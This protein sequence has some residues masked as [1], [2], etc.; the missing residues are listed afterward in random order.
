M[1]EAWIQM[2]SLGLKQLHGWSFI[3]LQGTITTFFTDHS[4]HPRYEEI[5]LLLKSLSKEIRKPSIPFNQEKFTKDFEKLE[6]NSLLLQ[7]LVHS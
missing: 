7:E 6:S 4:S 1:G 3:E 2:R 5:V